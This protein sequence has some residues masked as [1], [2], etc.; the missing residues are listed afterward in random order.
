MSKSSLLTRNKYLLTALFLSFSISCS[1]DIHSI[2]TKPLSVKNPTS[3]EFARPLSE[4]KEEVIN[5]FDTEKINPLT[6]EFYA[7]F[8]KTS[9]FFSAESK[10]DALFSKRVFEDPEN[11]N[12]LYLH[13]YGEPISSSAVYFGGGKP[14]RFRAAFQL[15]LTAPG[16]NSTKVS[17]VTH[18]PTV[19]NGSR[20]CGLHGYVSNDVPVEPT[21]IEEYKILLFIGRLLDARD[22]PPL[23]LPEDK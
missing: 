2:K 8:S 20:C 16:Q 14:L 3:Y 17:V 10:E 22:M 21:T 23:R 9:F 12:D 15:H 6:R 4:V 5:A 18:N 13:S 11:S 1:S 7:S 19:I